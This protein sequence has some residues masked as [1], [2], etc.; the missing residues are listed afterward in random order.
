MRKDKNNGEKIL[1][2]I[3]A[4]VG[5]AAE[6]RQLL[7]RMILRMHES[8]TYW[9]LANYKANEPVVAQD[10]VPALELRRT[11]RRLMRRWNGHWNEAAPK[12]ARYFA[13]S[14]KK[15]SDKVLKK[16]LK[17][18]GISVDFVLSDAMR[19]VLHATVIQNVALI[20]SI[21]QQYLQQVEGIVMRSVQTGRDVGQL[22][23][24]LQKQFGVTKRRAALIARDQNQK[25]TSALVR[26]RQLDLG[27]EEAIWLHSHAGKKP[28][29][30]HV[31]MNGKRYNIK[32]GIWDSHEK[33]FVHAG[34]L[35][36]CKC[37]S[38]PIIVGFS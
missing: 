22:S 9:L 28:R 25:A 29:P 10:A 20:K 37:I 23:K 1:R 15:R 11:L 14:T 38:K 4:N 36:N 16:I 6:Y 27:I 30:T 34:E 12:L 8:I 21:P 18:A 19:D 3:H 17:D 7:E 26:V 2:P 33:K 13:L 32:K 24:D 35:I 5:V 31:A